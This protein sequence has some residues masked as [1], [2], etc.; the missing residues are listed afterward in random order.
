MGNEIYFDTALGGYVKNDVIEK[1]EA[2]NKLIEEID[3]MMISDASINAELLKIRHMPLRKARILFLPA[4]GFSIS[5]TDS[6]IADL[7]REIADKVML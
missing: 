3:R 7:E 1:I 2:Y 6:F 5:Q 4:S